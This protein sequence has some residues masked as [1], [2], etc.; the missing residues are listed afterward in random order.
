MKITKYKRDDKEIETIWLSLMSIATMVDTD[1]YFLDILEMC[2]D[3]IKLYLESLK[4]SMMFK[5]KR[6]SSKNE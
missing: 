2:I 3:D 4:L 5:E 1:N 6:R